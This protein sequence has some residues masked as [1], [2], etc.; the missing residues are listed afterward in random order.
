ML[1]NLPS[2]VATLGGW[3]PLGARHVGW[4]CQLAGAIS[5]LAHFVGLSGGALFWPALGALWLVGA[6]FFSTFFFVDFTGQFVV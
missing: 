3:L 4:P 6:L 5:G 1:G 2:Y